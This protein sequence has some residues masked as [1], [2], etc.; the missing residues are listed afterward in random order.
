M[1][2]LFFLIIQAFLTTGLRRYEEYYI[3]DLEEKT[4]LEGYQKELRSAT[5]LAVTFIQNIYATPGL[6]DEEKL[7][8]AR[9]AV[10]SLRFGSDGYYSAYRAGTGENLIP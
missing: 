2:L 8:I 10:G 3:M 9:K 1:I 4:L 5:G 7:G 6:G